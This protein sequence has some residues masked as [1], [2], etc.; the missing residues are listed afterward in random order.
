M[1]A[2][3]PSVVALVALATAGCAVG[4]PGG[5]TGTAPRDDGG[6]DATIETD[7]SREPDADAGVLIGC[8][9]GGTT[10][11]SGTVYDP[12]GK[13]PLYDA[14]V[15]VPITTP[16][17]L[18]DGLVCDKC[19]GAVA[20]GGTLAAALTDAAGH[21]VLD[22]VHAGKDVPLVIQIGKW[23][24]QV[25]I[26]QVLACQNNA[27][28]DPDLLRLPRNANEGDIPHI[29]IATAS[30]DPMECLLLKTGI[31]AA[32]FTPPTGNGRVHTYVAAGGVQTKPASPAASTLWD[33]LATLER[34]DTVI[35][36]CEGDPLPDE[37]SAAAR[38]SLVDY[39]A[40]GGRLFITHYGYEWL[41]HGADPF[42]T[43][44]SWNVDSGG[45][46]DD[47][48]DPFDATIDVSFPKGKALADWLS[49]VGATATYGQ[50]PLFEPRHDVNAATPPTA[51]PRIGGAGL[52]APT[53][54]HLTFNTPIGAPADEQC[55]RVELSDFHVS[56]SERIAGQTFPSSCMGGVLTSQEKALEFMLFD[57]SACIVDD[58]TPPPPP[59]K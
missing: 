58:G 18:A 16:D 9:D 22:G 25:N 48:A 31:D 37:K 13:N 59:P 21:F 17:P 7:A 19:G 35:L 42:P 52:E 10:S 30:A 55:G 24:R 50:I 43:S 54:Q 32:E 26:P 36:P 2:F 1:R 39:S 6:S 34:Y 49:N 51:R 3:A 47:L 14:L 4:E 33:D 56:I 5:A 38:Q 45:P 57:L 11:I 46:L 27:I 23:R 41:A 8:A 15:Y 12:A 20:S 53:V 40:A 28:D 29:A 44:A